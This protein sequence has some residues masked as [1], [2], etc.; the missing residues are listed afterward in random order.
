MYCK[1]YGIRRFV[2]V[3]ALFFSLIHGY[4]FS[5]AGAIL[6]VISY[7]H[8]YFFL[9]TLYAMYR[10]IYIPIQMHICWNLTTIVVIGIF[11][12]EKL[13]PAAFFIISLL[14]L[15]YAIYRIIKTNRLMMAE[16]PV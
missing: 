10:N 15:S 7:I 12:G 11:H 6:F 1:E 9:A 2:L 3:S 4:S 16:G 14:I 5:V 13:A 8:S